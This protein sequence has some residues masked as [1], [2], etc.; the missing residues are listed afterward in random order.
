MKKSLIRQ[1]NHIPVYIEEDHHEVL[2]YIFKHIGAK[3]L[4]VEQNTLIHFDSHPDML[5]PEDLVPD[6]A[7]DK[8]K[9]FQKLS[10]E[11][12]ILPSVYIGLV[13]TIVWVCPWWCHQI[14]PGE[15][16]F[17]I[18][19][20]IVTNKLSVTCLESYYISEGLFTT[21]ENLENLKDVKL[22]VLQLEESDESMRRFSDKIIDIKQQVEE[23]GH[24]ILDFDLD[25]F[26]TL[27]PFVS[28]YP[29]AGVYQKLKSLYSI[30]PVPH[31][32]ETTA[33]IKL[34]LKSTEERV[35]MLENLK[36]IFTHLAMDGDLNMYEGPGEELIGP[37]SD[38]VVSIRKH[39]PRCD[40]DW[41]LIHDAGCTFDD[42]ELPH[43]ISSNSEIQSLF[44]MTERILDMLDLSPTVITMSRSSCDDYCPPHQVDDIQAGLLSLLH[45]KYGNLKENH[46]Y[47]E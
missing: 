40:I 37:V 33:K 41:R 5:I 35:E 39:Y 8:Y 24:Y 31:N 26:S 10:I 43:H 44:R 12:W 16:D 23:V 20:N 13:K 14:Q 38:I 30:S 3:N 47:R 21:R 25:F 11:N 6:E 4:P 36:L 2:P 17:E 9:L 15:Y 28:L 32:L 42:S 29:E 45:V 27:N 18:G 19:K 46:C 22:I 34:A 7:F 1:L